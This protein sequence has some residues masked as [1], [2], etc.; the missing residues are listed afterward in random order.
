MKLKKKLN[1]CYHFIKQKTLGRIF[2]PASVHSYVHLINIL[3][4]ISAI[5]DM[6]KRYCN[7]SYQC[8]K[9]KA[10]KFGLKSNTSLPND[11]YQDTLQ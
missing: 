3:C 10:K 5:T 4:N 7:I 2:F 1:K 11:S 6:N 9:R 8:L